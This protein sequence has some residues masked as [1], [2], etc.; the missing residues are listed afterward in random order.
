VGF[1]SSVRILEIPSGHIAPRRVCVAD[2][3]TVVLDL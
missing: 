1:V 2:G 3:V